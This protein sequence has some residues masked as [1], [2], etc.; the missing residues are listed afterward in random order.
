MFLTKARNQL[1]GDYFRPGRIKQWLI[2]NLAVVCLK[3]FNADKE[4]QEAVAII[5]V[6]APTKQ[7]EL[8][9]MQVNHLH[10]PRLPVMYPSLW[11]ILRYLL[12]FPNHVH[13]RLRA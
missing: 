11:Q 3:E 7:T 6:E 5:T 9:S 10:G 2:D 1:D 8:P 12:P 4:A 13:H